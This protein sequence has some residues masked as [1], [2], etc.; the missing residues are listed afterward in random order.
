MSLKVWYADEIDMLRAVIFWFNCIDFF[1]SGRAFW[2][3]FTYIYQ[4]ELKSLVLI[5]DRYLEEDISYW[6]YISIANFLSSKDEYFS[7]NRLRSR[8]GHFDSDFTI[9][10]FEVGRRI[11]VGSRAFRLRFNYIYQ[12]ELKSL[13]SR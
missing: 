10:H 2:L 7:S 4:F 6:N 11:R 8:V 3:R 5:V 12:F 13:V 9:Y 1:I